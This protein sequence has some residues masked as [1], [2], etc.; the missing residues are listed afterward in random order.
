MTSAIKQTAAA[1]I[2][3]Q[4]LCTSTQAPLPQHAIYTCPLLSKMI[5]MPEAKFSCNFSMA[6]QDYIVRWKASSLL[7]IIT[8]VALV[9][10]MYYTKVKRLWTSCMTYVLATWDLCPIRREIYCSAETRKRAYEGWP[11]WVR[12]VLKKIC[13]RGSRKWGPRGL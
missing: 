9:W 1:K 7:R 12:N 4:W 3:G 6:Q 2:H 13:Y 5:L 8:R 11:G 10:I